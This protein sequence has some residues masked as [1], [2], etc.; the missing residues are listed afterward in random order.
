MK[1]MHTLFAGLVM[2]LSVMVSPLASAAAT[3]HVPDSF[4]AAS[5]QGTINLST[6]TIKCA[7]IDITSYARA[8][9]VYLADVTQVAA[10][11]GYTAGGQTVTSTVVTADTTNHWTTIVVTP[12][13]W[14][15]ATT[16]SATGMACYSATASNRLILISDFGATVPS[17]GGTY[18]ISPV[19]LKFTH[20]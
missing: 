20:F 10:T 8:T 12:A 2:A 3:I 1:K 14:S 9:D 15:G 6:D 17:S 19:T 16:I 4:L 18:S 5:V 7:L 11:G 13:T